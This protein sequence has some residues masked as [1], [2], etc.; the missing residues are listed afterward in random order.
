MKVA[1]IF[2]R[3]RDQVHGMWPPLG[4]TTLGAV[5]KEQ[6]H[7]VRCHDTSFDPDLERVKAELAA[8]RPDLVGLST[9]TDFFAAAAE[10]IRYAKSLGAITVMGGPHP[11]IAPQK[12]LEAIPEL[13]YAVMGEGEQTL[14]QLVAQTLDPAEI[15]GL[16]FRRGGEIIINPPRPAEVDLDSLPIPDRDLLDVE[17]LYLKSRAINLHVS[18]GCPYRC[19]FCQPTLER[20]FGKKLKFRSPGLVIA[21][22]KQLHARYGI[23][24]F[25]FH[26]DTFTANRRWLAELVAAIQAAGLDRFRYVVNSRVDTF[27]EEAARLL[28]AMGCYYV[29]FGIESG[30]QKVL[31]SLDKGATVEQA[32]AAFALCRRFGFRTH[33]YVMLASPEEDAESLQATEDLI[34]E[35]KP[36]TVHISICTPL[37]GTRLAEDC[38][39]KGMIALSDFGDFDYYLKRNQAGQL[40]IPLKTLSYEQVLESR[41]RILKRR[42]LRVLA[43]NLRELY[44]DFRRDPD[45]G[46]FIFRYSF[47]RKMQHYFG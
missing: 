11:T 22:L 43:D 4:I 12:S 32:R 37:L 38:Q 25:F 8:F 30:S 28:R 36:H 1:L 40:P 44:R 42:R 39:T 45:L 34:A 24:D 6:G 35:L 5:L 46:K 17:P 20:M 29:L 3:R 31:D 9:L 2:P 19:R 14:T 47:Y 16:A 33:A 15:T 41:R 13:D 26:D 10:L 7:Q 23:T 18:R 27:S 21:E